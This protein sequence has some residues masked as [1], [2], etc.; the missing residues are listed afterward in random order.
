MSEKRHLKGWRKDTFDKRD[1]KYRTLFTRP[2][3]ELPEEVDLRKDMSAVEDQGHVGSCTANAAVGSMEF[4]KRDRL[5]RKFL[6]MKTQRDLSRLF[7]YYNTRMIEGTI[8]ADVG[9]SIRNTVKS[10]A[11]YGVC[12]S[13]SWPYQENKWDDKPDKDCYKEGEKF[14]V[15]SYYRVEN[16]PELLNAVADGYPVAFGAL[17]FESFNEAARTGIVEVP[18]TGEISMGAHAM[19]ICG[20]NRPKKRLLVRNS[21]GTRW[22][23]DGYCYMP[24]EYFSFGGLV[25]DFWVVKG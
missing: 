2:V 15:A 20:Y 12:Y 18:V 11:R 21:W 17:L 7:V 3:E 23:M 16:M 25:S 24:Y 9:A 1:L 8:D 5:N 4:L 19:L 10:L 13:R 14:K 6:C 22:G